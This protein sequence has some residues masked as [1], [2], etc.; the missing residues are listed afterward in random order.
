[1]GSA[2]YSA[3]LPPHSFI[4]VRNFESPKHLAQYLESLQYN[5]K[6]YLAYFDWKKTY[7]VQ[8]AV[9]DGFC[10]LCE[11]LNT[12]HSKRNIYTDIA[13]WQLGYC[14]KGLTENLMKN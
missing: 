12:K 1:M 2:N 10:K 5:H 7:H 14:N 3:L 9:Q 8:T 6:E 13:N 4:D 11:I